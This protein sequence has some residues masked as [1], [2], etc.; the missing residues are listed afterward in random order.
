MKYRKEPTKD[1]IV[2][3]RIDHATWSLLE[4]LKINISKM[5]RELITKEVHKLK[6][7]KL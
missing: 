4:R 6:K 2:A 3:F 5:A 1:K 7:E